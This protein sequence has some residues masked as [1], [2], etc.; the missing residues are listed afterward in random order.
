MRSSTAIVHLLGERLLSPW[1]SAKLGGV[2]R[3]FVAILIGLTMA[4]STGHAFVWPNTVE[5]VE[6]Q[7]HDNDVGVRRRAAQR[8]KDLPATAVRRLVNEALADPDVEV[9]I[10]AA[11][12]AMLV[13]GAATADR[14]VPWLNEPD[15]RLRRVAVELLRQN[16]NP[17]AIA[18]LGRV[19]SDP[20][21]DVRAATATALGESGSADAAVALLG[22]MDD[23]RPEV[24]IAVVSALARL[25]DRRAVVPLIGKV[26]DPHPGVRRSVA[27]A[28]GDLGDASA[29][30]ALILVLRDR[31]ET[32]RIAALEA[33]GDLGAAEATLSIASLVDEDRRPNVQRAAFAALARIGS[34]AGLEILITALGKPDEVDTAGVRAAL[35]QA[36]PRAGARL[37]KC[38]LGQPPAALADGCA[39]ALG[40][41]KT[42]E[43]RAAILDAL[44]RG[45]IRPI[46]AMT[47]LGA[48][49]DPEALP[50]V[51]EQLFAKDPYVRN[52]AID[53]A[54]QLLDP[55]R[56]DGRAVEPIAR[57]LD[58]ARRRRTER[59]ALT[60]LL[61]R[62]ASAR[63]APILVPL[64]GATDD[65]S[66]KIA[67][68]RALGQ[69]GRAGQDSVLLAALDD[70]KSDVRLEAAIA[71]RRTAA[72]QTAVTLLDRLT[73]AA[74]QD[75]AMIAIALVGALSVTRDATVAARTAKLIGEGEEGERDAMIE[76]LGAVPGVLGSAP[77]I[78]FA[79][80]RAEVAARAKIAEAL[81]SHPE[82]APFV[83]EMTRDVDGSVR[84]AAAWS[85][86]SIGNSA[87]HVSALAR[88]VEDRDVVV[89]GN[90]AGALGRLAVRGIAA[91]EPLCRAT[92]D[93]RSYVR[94]NSYAAL[95]V[96]GVRC[97]A[98]RE[99]RALLRDPDPLV[100]AS[101]ARLIARVHS[102]DAT[103][104]RAALRRCA[105]ED[106][107]GTVAI[108]CF[109]APTAQKPG[110]EPVIVYVVPNGQTA[111]VP[112]APFALVRADGL[113][114]LGLADRRGAVYEHDA[115]RGEL[116]LEVPA[117]LAR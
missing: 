39:L 75:R 102:D 86:G 106:T 11:E 25:R 90:A 13:G 72:Q 8:L 7:L 66:L 76:A 34:D 95:A 48:L 112:R 29:A 49:G 3:A 26:Q 69:I 37:A 55:S 116:R 111:P 54:A 85:L 27:R 107:S 70:E 9:R 64:A 38:L 62:T 52:A 87:A 94:A 117:P 17:A 99:R 93:R 19:L 89:A 73:R 20:D 71:L 15:A 22:H 60:A 88:A 83:V 30:S 92:N 109:S 65:E 36:G 4:T 10:A 84:A 61:G 91:K 105:A 97:D 6:K 31:D 53:A 28:L 5:R 16:P 81:A 23:Q 113:M 103:L 58:N 47:A 104:D 63:A 18:A 32:V 96:A 56:P 24:R 33:L 114:R 41:L 68:I 40:E 79:K 100:R 12:A 101:A 80:G 110:T 45:V 67:A 43:A 98:E 2:R 51:L 35:T 115:P 50:V 1:D 42:A 46:A 74:E 108:A 57:A 21:A 77:L 14:V 44:R 78:D 82:A 59:A